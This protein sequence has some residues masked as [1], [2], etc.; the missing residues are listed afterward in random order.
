MSESFTAKSFQPRNQE[1]DE[2]HCALLNS[3]LHSH[4]LKVYEILVLWMCPNMKLIKLQL[5]HFTFQNVFTFAT[6]NERLWLFRM[7]ITNCTNAQHRVLTMC[8][9]NYSIGIILGANTGWDV[10]AI[11]EYILQLFLIHY[12][13]QNYHYVVPWSWRYSK[14]KMP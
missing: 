12:Y 8:S 7:I 13:S 1:L 3:D 14:K 6:F 10:H 4:Y 11:L 5:K 9:W 2:Q